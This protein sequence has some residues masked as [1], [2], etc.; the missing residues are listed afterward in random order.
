MRLRSGRIIG[1]EANELE[2]LK[3]RMDKMEKDNLKLQLRV[4]RLRLR[5]NKQRQRMRRLRERSEVNYEE[6]S[7]VEAVGDIDEDS[8]GDCNECESYVTASKNGNGCAL[9]NYVGWLAIILVIVH[10]STMM[11]TV[12]GEH[13]MN[14]YRDHAEIM[15]EQSIRPALESARTRIVAYLPGEVA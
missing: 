8:C 1:D 3:Q 12:V 7:S 15:Y 4:E 6:N 10:F 13:D 9:F 11:H 14:Y 2:L 5:M